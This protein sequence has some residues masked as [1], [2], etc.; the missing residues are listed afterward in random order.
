VHYFFSVVSCMQIGQYTAPGVPHTL[1]EYVFETSKHNGKCPIFS[2]SPPQSYPQMP[3]WSHASI[4]HFKLSL[5]PSRLKHCLSGKR[6]LNML[7]WM[8]YFLQQLG[9]IARFTPGS[10]YLQFNSLLIDMVHRMAS[11][12]LLTGSRKI[13]CLSHDLVLLRSLSSFIVPTHF[14]TAI[15]MADAI[16]SSANDQGDDYA[17]TQ[18]LKLYRRAARLNPAAGVAWWGIGN[19]F[20]FWGARRCRS[21]LLLLPKRQR[22]EISFVSQV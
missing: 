3:V 8:L 22:V 10:P 15:K 11:S 16:F 20:E 13:T 4:H 17:I 6:P 19:C 12:E 7:I 9:G 1:L 2:L 18:A 5:R 14:D 21:C